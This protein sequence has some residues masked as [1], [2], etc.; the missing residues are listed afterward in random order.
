[1]ITKNIESK[2]LE[3][4]SEIIDAMT[5]AVNQ[6]K[7]LAIE[8]LPDIVYQYI[9]FE[10]VYISVLFVIA[11]LALWKGVRLLL[12]VV[13]NQFAVDV[14][15]LYFIVGLVLTVLGAFTALAQLKTL[16]MVWVAPKIFI[17]TKLVHLVK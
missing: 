16:L 1:M 8:Q 10:R 2:L 3:Q 5:N 9:L 7:D 17:I 4:A 15:F 11:L 6:A 14:D 13:S 12:K